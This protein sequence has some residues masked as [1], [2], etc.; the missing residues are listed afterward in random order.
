MASGPAPGVGSGNSVIAPC[1]VMRPILLPVFSA[2]QRSSFGPS[3]MPI[4][5]AFGVGSANSL[6]EESLGSNRPILDAPLS[7]N[8]RQPS[9]PSTAI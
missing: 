2:N 4:G 1:S 9:A 8:H 3:M 5:V 7:Q 6:N